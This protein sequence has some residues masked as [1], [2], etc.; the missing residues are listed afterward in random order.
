MAIHNITKE[1]KNQELLACL[2]FSSIEMYF[3]VIT[4]KS[5][6]QANGIDIHLSLSFIG[7]SFSEQKLT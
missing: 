1:G 5:L 6:Y 3:I 7:H 2:F 4:S